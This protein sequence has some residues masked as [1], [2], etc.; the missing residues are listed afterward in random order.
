[1][2]SG[3]PGGGCVARKGLHVRTVT[4]VLIYFSSQYRGVFLFYLQ[5]V[6]LPTSRASKAELGARKIYTMQAKTEREAR[7]KGHLQLRRPRRTLGK[8]REHATLQYHVL[9]LR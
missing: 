4:K 6:D 3:G 1:M 2:L 9:Y 7:G 8:S 5:H